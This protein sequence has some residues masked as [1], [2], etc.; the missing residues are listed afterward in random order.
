MTQ[1]D[2]TIVRVG[3]DRV[4]LRGLKSAIEE[5]AQ[6]PGDKTDEEI[7]RAL[8]DKLS[9]KNYIADCARNEYGQA[10]V[11]EYR[12]FMGQAVEDVPPKGLSVTVLGPGCAQCNRLEQ[13]VMQV[14]T[15][16]KLGAA[17]D[18]VTDIKEIGKYGVISTPA[19]L[20]NGKIVAKGTVPSARRIKEWLT[21]AGA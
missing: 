21:D 4:G 14:L 8:L 16:L 18:H 1:D 7:A 5:I 3:D 19:L 6:S 10:L 15:E 9:R 17:V 12:K 13:L 20:I 11:R 2:H